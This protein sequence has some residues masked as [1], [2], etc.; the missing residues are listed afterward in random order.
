MGAGTPRRLNDVLA[1]AG[2]A[3]PNLGDIDQSIGGA[4]ATATHGTG[5]EYGNLATTVGMGAGHR[6]GDVVRTSVDKQSDVLHA[7]RVGLL[8]IVTEVTLRS[9]PARPHARES[10]EVDFDDVLDDFAAQSGAV[11]HSSCTG[12]RG[13]GGAR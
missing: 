13:R 1:E 9:A 2:L 6:S 11:D 8:G 5:L 10:V 7:A 12:C 4:I 3:M